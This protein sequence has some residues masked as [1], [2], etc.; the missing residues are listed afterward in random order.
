MGVIEFTIQVDLEHT[1]SETC[2]QPFAPCRS[3]RGVAFRLEITHIMV[4]SEGGECIDIP[5][6]GTVDGRI[7]HQSHLRVPI[8]IDIGRLRGSSTRLRVVGHLVADAVARG[9]EVHVC[10]DGALM[11]GHICIVKRPEVM[12]ERG[13]EPWVT[14]PDVHRVGIVGDVEQVG[15]AWL[16]RLSSV[17]DAQVAEF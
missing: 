7:E 2:R 5:I 12:G 11:V 1:V 16:A 14:L 13:F 10:H 8:A 6:A 3:A 17:V 15:H 4:I 9:A